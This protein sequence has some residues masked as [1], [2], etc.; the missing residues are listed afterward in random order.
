MSDIWLPLDRINPKPRQ[1]VMS[2]ERNLPQSK[3]SD[4]ESVQN[5]PFRPPQSPPAAKSNHLLS[6]KAARS[7]LR[8]FLGWVG[9]PGLIGAGWGWM[10]GRGDWRAPLVIG[11]VGIVLGT[12][13]FVV[14]NV[15]HRAL[16]VDKSRTN[17][18]GIVGAL[19]GSVLGAYIGAVTN[20]GRPMIALFNPDLPE[21]DFLV[22]FGAIGGFFI[23]AVAGACLLPA[24]ITLLVYIKA[25]IMDSKDSGV[26]P[27]T[28]TLTAGDLRN[29]NSGTQSDACFYDAPDFDY[30]PTLNHLKTVDGLILQS[31]S[32]DPTD[33]TALDRERSQIWEMRFH[34]D[35]Y[36]FLV[37]TNHHGTTTNFYTC[38]ANVPHDVLLDLL[39]I[40]GQIGPLK[41]N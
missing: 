13:G 24:T 23:G 14:T 33:R 29:Y 18:L 15:L 36:D 38:S 26:D 7:L 3:S 40:F 4:L 30:E 16:K 22:S 5:S 2:P 11:G 1:S 37:E 19:V 20:L 17:Y 32:I 21:M 8:S 25:R 9:V 39:E 12:L 35:G 6:S 41:W 28:T 31:H 34:Y 10:I 27:Q